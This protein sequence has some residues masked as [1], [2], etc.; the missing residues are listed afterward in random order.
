MAGGGRGVAQGGVARVEG[1]RMEAEG[2]VAACSSLDGKT[3]PGKGIRP[4]ITGHR[5]LPSQE[6]ASF[7]FRT[8]N[9]ELS[10]FE[11]P[12]RIVELA[13]VYVIPHSL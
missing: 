3:N 11:C 6:N 8:M 5:N 2:T 1:F 13:W 7:G 9:G 10:A 12:Q 4:A